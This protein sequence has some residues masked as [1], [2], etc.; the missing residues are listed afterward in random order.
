MGGD[1]AGADLVGA[2]EFGVAGG[3]GLGG[4]IGAGAPIVARKPVVAVGAQRHSVAA[5]RA[6]PA[7]VGDL[8][9]RQL[10]GGAPLGALVLAVRRAVLVGIGV[11]PGAIHG[12]LAIPSLFGC[13]R[14]SLLLGGVTGDL[15]D[16][17]PLRMPAR[18]GGQ[19]Q[20]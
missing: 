20:V 8:A 11:S 7:R 13:P 12:A 2:G 15:L 14:P 1:D 5:G 16:H 6:G 3:T 10:V 19:R 17:Q 9:G 18:E 4:V